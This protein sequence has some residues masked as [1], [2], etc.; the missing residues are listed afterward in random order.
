MNNDID[1]DDQLHLAWIENNDPDFD[2][3]DDELEQVELYEDKLWNSW[4]T[5]MSFCNENRDKR[6]AKYDYAIRA[7]ANAQ[8][9]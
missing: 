6:D 1:D 7:F 2:D 3:D 5:G 9:T 8:M 4:N